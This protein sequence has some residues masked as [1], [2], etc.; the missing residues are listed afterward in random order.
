MPTRNRST[1]ESGRGETDEAGL[2]A[3][4]GSVRITQLFHLETLRARTPGKTVPSHFGWCFSEWDG[5]GEVS[6]A[7]LRRGPDAFRTGGWRVDGWGDEGVGILG[8]VT[9]LLG[10]A[11][12][13]LSGL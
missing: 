9:L 1:T 12:V 7:E 10:V 8:A 13:L 2:V 5:G 3:D 11:I 6:G 4:T